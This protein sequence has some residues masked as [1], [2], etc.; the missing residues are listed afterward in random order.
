MSPQAD[1]SFVETEEDIET[2]SEVVEETEFEESNNLTTCEYTQ[3]GF[4]A[5][6]AEQ[7]G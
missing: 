5:D 1:E 4:F 3:I 6:G 2:P 7:L